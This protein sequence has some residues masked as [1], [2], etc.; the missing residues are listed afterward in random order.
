MTKLSDFNYDLPK[1]LIAQEG[2]PEREKARLLV[3]RPNLPIEHKR[4]QDLSDY[5]KEGDL[6]VL[7]DTKVLRSK[8]L[9]KKKS[10]GKIDCLLLPQLNGS[11]KNRAV[12]EALVRGANVKEGTEISFSSLNAQEIL[13]AKVLRSLG[14]AKVEIEFENPALI[15]KVAELPFPPY[16]K[17][18]PQHPELYQTVYSKAEGS[19]AAPTAGLHFT[20]G[21]MK[22][23]AEKGVEFASLTLHVGLGTFAPIQT[24]NIEEWKMHPEYFSVTSENAEILNR[25]IAQKRRIFAVGTTSVRT[26]ESVTEDEKVKAGEGWTEIY[27]YP[28]YSFK[29]P[30]AGLLTNFHLPQSTLLLLVSALIGKKELFRA[31]QE[32]IKEQYR[33]YSLGDGMLYLRSG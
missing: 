10:G 27:I 8:L 18:I 31:Y 2:L 25:A 22:K 16:I 5:L 29:F 9:G 32:A 33:F 30:Y 19:L 13:N 26:L 28:G 12:R 11:K 6:V 17:R 20:E 14:G 23:I 21:L 24:E 4:I 3:L 1:E 15:E 7:N